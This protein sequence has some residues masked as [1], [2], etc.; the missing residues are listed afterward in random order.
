MPVKV[1]GP[2][3]ALN[4]AEKGFLAIRADRNQPTWLSLNIEGN[5]RAVEL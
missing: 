2:V 1:P 4:I 5:S 3:Y